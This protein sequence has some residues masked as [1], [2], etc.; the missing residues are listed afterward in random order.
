MGSG[1]EQLRVV[2]TF[3]NATVSAGESRNTCASEPE[4]V[5][6]IHTTWGQGGAPY[7]IHVANCTD[8]PPLIGNL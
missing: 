6:V 3:V 8:T 2:G 7:G 4:T 5:G 1:A